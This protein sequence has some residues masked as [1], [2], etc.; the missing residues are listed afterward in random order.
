M[1]Y[2]CKTRG[3]R[4]FH[5]WQAAKDDRGASCMCCAKLLTQSGSMSDQ[6]RAAVDHLSVCD[7][8][9]HWMPDE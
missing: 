5:F 2:S 1:P 9:E 3:W 6:V 7:H 4:Q 8:D